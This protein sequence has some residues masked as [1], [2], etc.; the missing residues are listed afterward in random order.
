MS[1]R[2]DCELFCQRL[3]SYNVQDGPKSKPL[4]IINKIVLHK[5]WHWD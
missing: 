4:Q 2:T 1:A 5:V 3:V